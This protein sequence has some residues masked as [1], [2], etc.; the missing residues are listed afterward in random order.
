MPGIDYRTASPS[1]S[2]FVGKAICQ[3]PVTASEE[4]LI[5]MCPP[6]IRIP[7]PT[8]HNESVLTQSN[9]PTAVSE[10][11]KPHRTVSEFAH[12][13]AIVIAES[14]RYGI[15]WLPGSRKLS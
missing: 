6:E 13:A 15:E 14:R 10:A 7:V 12:S 5:L 1:A 3:A 11:L 9:G 8:V 2:L 4:E